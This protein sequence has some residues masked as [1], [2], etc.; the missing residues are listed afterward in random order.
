MK[1]HRFL[2]LVGA[3]LLALTPPMPAW[4]DTDPEAAVVEELVVS[5]PGGGPAW[6]RVTKGDHVVW[7]MG[8]PGGL[9]RG[10]AWDKGLLRQRL[11]GANVLILPAMATASLR[12]VPGFMGLLRG[13]K[14][15]VDLEPGLPP[16]LRTRFVAARTA[17]RQKPEHYARLNAFGVAL[18]LLADY[19]R[20]LRFDGAQPIS[21]I[22]TA[23]RRNRVRGQRAASYAAVPLFRAV[24][25]GLTPA[26][27]MACL[28]D[29][30]T[31]VEAGAGR[32]RTAAAGWA[33]GD[34]RVALTAERGFD[35]CL[36][37][38]PGIPDRTRQD[39]TAEANAIAAALAKPGHAVAVIPL[40]RLVAR[41]GVLD[42]LRAKGYEVRTPAS[43]N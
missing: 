14:A 17:L 16:A 11:E 27:G 6:W 28:E 20:T 13:L 5:G 18:T 26:I 15:P 8:V 43:A 37:L 24:E 39:M 36:S 31:E 38:L 19:G 34:V 1:L 2:G 3:L 7:V 40:R 30:L 35:K 29:A 33:R 9:P 23:A 32:A 22:T 4:A 42:Q 25:R 21:A 12:D 41:G 10:Q